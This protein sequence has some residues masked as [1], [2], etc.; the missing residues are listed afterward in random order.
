MIA[1]F[2]SLAKGVIEFAR[3]YQS[4]YKTRK[5]GGTF[6]KKNDLSVLK[7]L[8]LSKIYLLNILWHLA[9][10]EQIGLTS[11]FKQLHTE[12]LRGR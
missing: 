7:A 2:A 10:S 4:D 12:I 1:K 9:M 8:I 11:D 6:L 5:K 3:I